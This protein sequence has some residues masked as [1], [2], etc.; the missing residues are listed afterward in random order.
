[1]SRILQ[2]I[3]LVVTGEAR[4]L[5]EFYPKVVKRRRRRRKA[6]AAEMVRGLDRIFGL[7]K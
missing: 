4:K 5:S 3:V 7:R 2:T 1:M 6:S